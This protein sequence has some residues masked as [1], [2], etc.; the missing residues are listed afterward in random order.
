[1]KEIS[2]GGFP[3]FFDILWFW[4]FNIAAFL[5][6]VELFEPKFLNWPNP[7]KLFWDSL[8]GGLM[9]GGERLGHGNSHEPIKISTAVREGNYLNAKKNTKL[10]LSEA[11]AR[12][13]LID[14]E[15]MRV[16]LQDQIELVQFIL[17]IIMG[18][19]D[20]T[21][22]HMETQKDLIQIGHGRSLS[23]D[24]LAVDSDGT[25]YDIEIQRSSGGAQ[26][27]FPS[28]RIPQFCK[29]KSPGL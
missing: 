11:I 21:V 7:L 5:F 25:Q 4:T 13:R 9:H 8:T 2:I 26:P 27:C 20:L 15:M 18:M 29:E 22:I 3:F 16:A 17:R 6:S 12:L 28:R 1:M 24:V 19:P 23:L 14:D 10:T